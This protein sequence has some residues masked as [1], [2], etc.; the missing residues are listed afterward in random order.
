MNIKN[1]ADSRPLCLFLASSLLLFLLLTPYAAS[2][3]TLRVMLEPFP[4]IIAEDGT[5]PY[6]DLLREAG[7][8]MGVEVS[9]TM[10]AYVR[11]KRALNEGNVDVIGLVPVGDEVDD[12][13]TYGHEL[14]FTLPAPCDLY[15]ANKNM[16]DRPEI[17]TVGV[18]SGNEVFASL[19]TGIPVENFYPHNDLKGL[20]KMLLSGRVDAL[21]FA[22]VPVVLALADV[23][24]RLFFQQLPHR[25]MRVGLAT[26]N[27]PEGRALGRQ[28]E[29]V[30]SAIEPKI[31]LQEYYA[32]VTQSAPGDIVESASIPASGVLD[33]YKARV[34]DAGSGIPTVFHRPQRQ[35]GQEAE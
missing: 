28:L 5:G 33:F 34:S 32:L 2:A 30:L 10:G 12:F 3:K 13:Y 31:R 4:P 35:N 16:L 26:Q 15:V 25:A 1:V 11:A 7:E 23:G 8:A 9:I 17:L 18:P 29:A 22:R 14:S 6:V 21:W 27:T 19:V 24:G 20:V